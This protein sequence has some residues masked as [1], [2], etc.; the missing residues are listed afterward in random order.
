MLIMR[1]SVA[2]A[3]LLSVLAARPLEAEPID[4]ALR[5]DIEKLLTVTGTDKAATQMAAMTAERMVEALQKSRPHLSENAF[6]LAKEI[7]AGE[8]AR[9][10]TG[11]DGLSARLVTIYARHFTH[12]E[13]KQLVKFYGSDLGRKTIEA[14]P[15]LMQESA[16][17]GQEWMLAHMGQISVALDTRLKEE[18]FLE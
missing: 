16:A 7:L 11:P 18:G 6:A 10:Y 9:A 8:F 1:W 15:M 13:V 17:A 12:Q 3:A 14:M 4:P 2:I 5:A